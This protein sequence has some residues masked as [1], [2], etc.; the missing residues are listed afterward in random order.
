MMEEV[1]GEIKDLFVTHRVESYVVH[2]KEMRAKMK[3]INSAQK[4]Q[5][6]IHQLVRQDLVF[7]FHQRK[8]K[9]VEAQGESTGKE[10]QKATAQ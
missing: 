9:A 8:L 7:Y 6:P 5:I 1:I 2:L 10:Q 3:Q 4:K